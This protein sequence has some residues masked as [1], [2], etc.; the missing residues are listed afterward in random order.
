MG[1]HAPWDMPTEPK[2]D[3]ELIDIY[4]QYVLLHHALVPYTYANAQEAP[5]LRKADRQ[6]AGVQ[7]PR[8]PEGE[9]PLVG[10]REQKVHLPAGK[11]GRLLEPRE[12]GGGPGD[13]VEP[14]PLE[15]IPIFMRQGAPV[16]GTL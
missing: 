5:P 8:R 4:R 6:A 1:S 13:L 11:W 3:T 15:R 16:L 12:G 14:A 10:Q 9:A 2:V 7:L